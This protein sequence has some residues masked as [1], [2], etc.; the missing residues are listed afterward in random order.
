MKGYIYIFISAF[1]MSFSF[2]GLNNELKNYMNNRLINRLMES[3]MFRSIGRLNI[4]Y[5]D[6]WI[7][8]CQIILYILSDDTLLFPM[9][10]RINPALMIFCNIYISWDGS[11]SEGKLS[12]FIQRQ[13]SGTL[14][15]FS[16]VF[17]T[18]FVVTI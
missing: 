17:E 1:L 13:Y 2:N 3:L 6:G 11:Y 8:T 7:D 10:W 18:I 14:L 16:T 5:Q 15:N 9:D 4:E 12:T